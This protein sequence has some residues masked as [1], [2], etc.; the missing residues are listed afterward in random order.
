MMPTE[1]S[2]S[3]SDILVAVLTLVA[4]GLGY[5]IKEQFDKIKTIQNQLSDKK[6]KVYH[7][8]YS[9]FFDLLKQQ[10][11][12]QKKND[13]T[14]VVQLIDIKKDLFIYAPDNIVKKFMEW[15]G[16]INNHSG[17]IKHIV[18]FLDLFVLIRKDMGQHKTEI[19]SLDILRSTMTT[20]EE[21]ENMK[22]LLK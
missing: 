7:E 21:F 14:L 9:V 13:N 22:K 15:N 4:A 3:L 1:I 19:T 2:I 10:K 5:V 6:Y 17:D 16:Y 8:I 12:L 18:V 11:G 20:D